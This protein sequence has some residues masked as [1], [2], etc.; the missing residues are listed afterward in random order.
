MVNFW[1]KYVDEVSIKPATPRWDS[2]N[3]E[4]FFTTESCMQLWE[5]LYVWYDGE[6]NPCDFDYKSYL[7]MGNIKNSTLKEIWRSTQYENL[8][9]KHLEKKRSKCFPCDRCPL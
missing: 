8:R 6:I 5:R 7:S 4:S 1:K 9:R 2:Y 3:N